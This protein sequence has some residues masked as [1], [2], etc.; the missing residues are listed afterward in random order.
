MAKLTPDELQQARLRSGKLGGRPR[1]PTVAEARQAALD[2]L[3]PK[4][5]K[6]LEAHLGEGDEANPDAWRAALR[7]FEHEFGR[8]GEMSEPEPEAIF[9]ARAMTPEQRKAAIAELL[10]K[11]PGLAV[12]VR[13]TR[14]A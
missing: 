2:R 9:D 7:V 14:P 10:E 5:L 13:G 3:T 1:K 4:A 6:V 11:H 12:L 8:P